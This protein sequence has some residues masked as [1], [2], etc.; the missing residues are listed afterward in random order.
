MSLV[1]IAVTRDAGVNCGA[2]YYTDT[3]ERAWFPSLGCNSRCAALGFSGCAREKAP[4]CLAPGQ[5]IRWMKAHQTQTAV[6]RGMVTGA[7][8]HGNVKL[9]Y[10]LIKALLLTA[11]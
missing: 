6:E 11:C 4:S 5:Q 1:D 2:G 10:W 3:Q 8:H 7:D 9:M